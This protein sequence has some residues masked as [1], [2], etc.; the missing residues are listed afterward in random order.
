MSKKTIVWLIV[1]VLVVIGIWMIYKNSNQNYN[2]NGDSAFL[3]SPTP[4]P[5]KVVTKP[6]TGAKPV[7][8]SMTYSQAVAMYKDSRIQFNEL[9]QATPGQ[10]ALKSGQ[11]VMLD[12]RTS[13]EITLTMDGKQYVVAGYGW[14][15]VTASTSRPLPYDLDITCKTAKNSIPNASRIYLQADISSGL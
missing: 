4:T 7:G 6:K 8:E 2:L 15:V 14:K 11:K 13:S 3:N 12:N 9:C 5:S 10:M 1:A